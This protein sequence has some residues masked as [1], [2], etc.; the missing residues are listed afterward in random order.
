[1]KNKAYPICWSPQSGNEEKDINTVYAAMENPDDYKLLRLA[2]EEGSTA[3]HGEHIQAMEVVSDVLVKVDD[4]SLEDLV[5][6]AKER[7]Y[8]SQQFLAQLL[9]EGAGQ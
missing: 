3:F 1:M 8:T 4:L 9:D 6:L 7:G 5:A 2:D